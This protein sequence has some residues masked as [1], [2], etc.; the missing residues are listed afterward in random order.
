MTDAATV[1]IEC[2]NAGVRRQ[3]ESLIASC[4]EFRLMPSK[5][6]RPPDL[7][8][9][10]CDE[11]NPARTFAAIKGVLAEDSHV[12]IFLTA[13]QAD[14]H[15]ILEAFR[16]GVKE[17]LPQP[18]TE[19]DLEAAVGRFL[20][21]FRTRPP[22]SGPK[23]GT[24][25]SVIGAKG[26]AGT[27]TVAVN[28]AVCARQV[29]PESSSAL[30]DLN[31]YDDELSIFLDAK[32]PRGLRD[33]SGDISRLDETMLE[34]VLAKHESGVSLLSSGG[35]DELMGGRPARGCAARALELLRGMFP[36]VFVDAGHILEPAVKEA[37]GGSATIMLVTTLSVPAIRR[38]QQLL[39][40]LHTPEFGHSKIELVVNRYHAS[41]AELLRQTEDVLQQ[42]ATWLIPVDDLAANGSLNKG[43]PLTTFAPKAGI[44]KE[45]L[46]HA[47]DLCGVVADRKGEKR[48]GLLARWLPSLIGNQPTHSS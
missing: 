9:L 42:K 33:L 7:L 37:L 21:R 34:S 20:E 10:E 28:L 40:L 11:A 5:G 15:L 29:H 24:V 2:D 23:L 1:V 22:A 46:K 17:V 39:G 36:Y 26:G 48:G 25:I 4:A 27:S 19:T 8:I 45:Y 16:V 35:Y 18:I 6:R 30:V 47:G 44:T 31:F 13:A 41:D 38:A 32:T 14:S 12:E 43:V 3:F